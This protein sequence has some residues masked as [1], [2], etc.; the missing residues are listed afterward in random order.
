MAGYWACLGSWIIGVDYK[1]KAKKRGEN[2]EWRKDNNTI[3][4]IFLGGKNFLARGSSYCA[5]I[6]Y[7][8]HMLI[9]HVA[10]SCLPRHDINPGKRHV[11]P[12]VFLFPVYVPSDGAPSGEGAG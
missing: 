12:G 2:L 8:P 3:R 6:H 4:K 1:V 10:G 7:L 11:P 9:P 5:G